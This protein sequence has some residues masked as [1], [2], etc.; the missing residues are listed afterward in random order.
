MKTRFYELGSNLKKILYNE[1]EKNEETVYIFENPATYFEIKRE[2]FKENDNLFCNFKLL[3]ESDFYEKLLETDKIVIREE[4]QV[5]LFYNTLTEKIRKKLRVEN[6]YDIID[7]AYNFY[8]LF[9]E[10]QEYKVDI[11]K[12]ETE[13][14]QKEIFE[15]L[16]EINESLKNEIQQKGL[17]LP[18]MLRKTENIS[19]RFIKKYKRICFV[20]KVKFTPF[21]KDVL[22][23]FSRKGM[24]TENILQIDRNDFDEEKLEIKNSFGLPDKKFF[25]KKNMNIE[26]HQFENK[27]T[28]LMGMVKKLEKNSRGK[29]EEDTDQYR[30]YDGQEMN[31]KA[32]KD[33]QLLNQN[34]ITYNLEETMQNT[35]IY[36]VLSIVCSILENVKVENGTDRKKKLLFKVKVLYNGFKSEE[37][38]NI[39]GLKKLY[40]QFH[41]IVNENY[42]YISRDM[43]EKDDGKNWDRN[44]G[45]ER[46]TGFTAFLDELEKLYN[47]NNMN[48]YGKYLEEIFKRHGEIEDNIRGKYFEALSEM[49]V[50]EDFSFDNLW[51]KFFNGNISASLL[52]MFLKYLDKKAISLDLEEIDEQEEEKRYKINTFSAIS[53]MKKKNIIFLNLQDTFPKVKVNNYLF[54]KGQR[55]S[56]GLPVVEKER[57]KEFFRFFNNIFGAENI[58]LSYVK[59][60][61]ENTDCAGIIEEIKLKYEVKP[62]FESS[63]GEISE[64]EELNFIKKYFTPKGEKWEK[65]DIGKFIQSKLTKDRKK[66]KEEKLSLGYYS[67]EKLRDFEY[68][69][70]IEKMIGNTELEEISDR[71]DPLLFGN[72][73]HAFYEKIVK[74]NKEIIEKKEY[75]TD[76]QE[77][78]NT[79]SNI[80]AAFEYK[81]PAEF[82]RFYREVSFDEIAKSIKKFLDALK[83][84]TIEE[85]EKVTD[86]EI[87]S[88]EKVR[89]KLEK[90][91]ENIKYH[92]VLINGIMDLYIKVDKHEILIDYKSGNLDKDR[93]KKAQEQLDFYSIILGDEQLNRRSKYVVDTW[94]GE[95]KKDE[96]EKGTDKKIHLSKDIIDE[97]VKN[98]FERD[99]YGLGEKNSSF[100]HRLY[101]DIVRRED[102]NEDD[103]K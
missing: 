81:I 69:Y 8:N 57:L 101:K 67:F 42:K 24:K 60:L 3:K 73:I 17:I 9:S 76:M 62:K 39:F 64:G 12:I 51:K 38:L 99:F 49:T 30:I 80:L 97:V 37:F 18:Y 13:E 88:E 85:L 7:L 47:I 2:Y 86:F 71:I 83:N 33:Y 84:G 93:L 29:M 82:I 4:K 102:E 50:L 20:N 48:D 21:E 53:D 77:I 61:D 10:L 63:Q 55:M 65:K 92:N 5:I 11:Y 66:L 16:I 41:G 98:Y 43:L 26:I 40:Q 14:W 79:L 59:N 28:Q 54:S 68:G 6:Y 35:K 31:S 1:F 90:G 32:K 56:M 19:D 34:R 100:N 27:F 94:N 87:Y 25:Q 52:K 23:L 89:H 78:K 44:H 95:I 45:E 103:R 75:V 74:D 96:R 91:L 58:Y 70:Y 46:E 22:E 15:I 72:I 36:R